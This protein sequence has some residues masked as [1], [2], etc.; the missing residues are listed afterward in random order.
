MFFLHARA[1]EG[2]RVMLCIRGNISEN[3]TPYFINGEA[4]YLGEQVA[5]TS[6]RIIK[7]VGEV[8]IINNQISFHFTDDDFKKLIA[9]KEETGYSLMDGGPWEIRQTTVEDKLPAGIG[10]FTYMYNSAKKPFVNLSM[11]LNFNNS[12]FFKTNDP[13]LDHDMGASMIL[14]K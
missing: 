6:R 1:K 11:F 3:G 12:A 14:R 5:P 4:I 8:Q 7:K 2:S 9:Y 10:T 13:D